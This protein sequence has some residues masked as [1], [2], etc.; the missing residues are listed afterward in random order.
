MFRIQ[1]N[2][3]TW[4]RTTNQCGS[5]SSNNQ[6]EPAA[7]VSQSVSVVTLPLVS[8]ATARLGLTAWLTVAQCSSRRYRAAPSSSSPLPNCIVH[9][10]ARSATA[11]QN[12]ATPPMF[13]LVIAGRPL[14]TNF[15]PVDAKKMMAAIPHPAA[16]HEFTI[17][18]LQPALPPVSTHSSQQPATA[19]EAQR[20]YR[21]VD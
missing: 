17:A 9:D 15:Q 18:L 2:D 8:D 21:H 13:A 4:T 1:L 19:A 11:M 14:D 12:G 16:V 7:K 5:G 20:A 10:S 3:V 6:T